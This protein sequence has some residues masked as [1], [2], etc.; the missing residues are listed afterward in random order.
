MTLAKG[1]PWLSSVGLHL[2]VGALALWVFV[3]PP[4]S[5]PRVVQMHLVSGRPGA[6]TVARGASTW[7][8]TNAPLVSGHPEPA[9]PGW[10]DARATGTTPVPSALVPVALEDLL[11]GTS[12]S[13]VSG[14]SGAV[15]TGWVS[16]GGEG[17]QMP[18]LPPPFLTP[19]QGARWTLLVSVPGS[20]GY[21]TAV[22]GLDSGHPDLDLWLEGHLRAIT[23]PASLD[24]RDYELRW[25]L[26][27]ESG[28]PQ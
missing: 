12:T 10:S 21:P 6:A 13:E 18:P 24:G 9:V 1:L 27:L 20:G 2:V 28:R 7:V 14:E 11:A 16:P 23:F 8:P 22:E 26:R 17:Y 5:G 15:A 3:Q 25:V 19:P 4:A